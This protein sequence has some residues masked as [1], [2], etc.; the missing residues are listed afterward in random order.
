[1]IKGRRRMTG[2]RRRHVRRQRR[3]KAPKVSSLLL[4]S[5]E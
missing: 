1:M 4:T 5:F 3:V 2:G